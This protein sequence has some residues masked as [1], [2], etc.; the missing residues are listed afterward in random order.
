LAHGAATGY[1]IPWDAYASGGE[2]MASAN[3]G[4]NGMAGQ[5]I[6]GGTSSEDGKIGAGFW[7]V[8]TETLFHIFL[9]LIIR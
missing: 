9:P 8:F 6:V 1:Q 5:A 4:I 3:Y 2:Q 7:T